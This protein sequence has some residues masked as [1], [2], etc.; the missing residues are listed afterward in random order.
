LRDWG[1]FFTRQPGNL[2][3]GNVDRVKERSLLN[4][5]DFKGFMVKGER[6]GKAGIR[7]RFLLIRMYGKISATRGEESSFGGPQVGLGEVSGG[8]RGYN[9]AAVG[10]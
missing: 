9:K 3:I 8:V 2:K 7:G 1:L 4:G 5:L 10:Q 6:G